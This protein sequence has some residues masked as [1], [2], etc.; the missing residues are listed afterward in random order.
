MMHASKNERGHR[1]CAA[2]KHLRR[3]C[4]ENCVLAPY[5]PGNKIEEFQAVQTV[6]GVSNLIKL[7]KRVRKEH[8][9]TVV[10]SL[11][12]EAKCRLEDPVLGSSLY[13]IMY[14][15]LRQQIYRNNN[16]NRNQNHHQILQLPLPH[17]QLHH[18]E[19]ELKNFQNHLVVNGESSSVEDGWEFLHSNNKNN[20]S[21]VPVLCGLIYC[22]FLG[23]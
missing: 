1:A 6:F 20:M 7:V 3:R 22:S 5:F 14:D 18:Q 2:C 16:C 19:D 15:N 10:E 13:K 11:I 4:H 12:W 9:K 23:H 21:V 17:H 8:R